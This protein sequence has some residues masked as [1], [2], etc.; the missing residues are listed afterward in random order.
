MYELGKACEKAAESFA[1]FLSAW[2]KAQNEQM[3]ADRCEWGVSCDE[4]ALWVL[5][6]W[7]YYEHRM[8]HVRAGARLKFW[9]FLCRPLYKIR[10]FWEQ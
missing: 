8:Q 4:Q 6:G 2:Q 9:D 5:F 10:R 1:N 7:D 3:E